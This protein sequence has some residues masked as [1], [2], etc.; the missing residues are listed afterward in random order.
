MF[1]FAQLCFCVLDLPFFLNNSFLR[2]AP[3]LPSRS[4]CGTLVG[5]STLLLS[6]FLSRV[7]IF[8]FPVCF[9]CGPFLV[10][11]LS[12]LL[13]LLHPAQL[14]VGER[15]L[16][17]LAGSGLEA[18]TFQSGLACLLLELLRFFLFTFSSFF[19]PL[20]LCSCLP[21][22]CPLSITTKDFRGVFSFTL[23]MRSADRVNKIGVFKADPGFSVHL[24]C[25]VSRFHNLSA[26]RN[27]SCLR[28]PLGRRRW[29]RQISRRIMDYCRPISRR[30]RERWRSRLGWSVQGRSLADDRRS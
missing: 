30:S 26:V 25:G 14:P 13:P 17:T 20:S 18:S 12:R 21:Q 7:L 4:I 10:F 16:G 6:C 3:S 23:K 19:L 29:Q 8:P 22:A 1:P 11:Q 15:V 28:W 2:L 5:F 24:L 9:L 27:G